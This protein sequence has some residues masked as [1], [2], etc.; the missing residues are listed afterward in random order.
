MSEDNKIVESIARIDERIKNVHDDVR[1]I[2]VDTKLIRS[3][4]QAHGT[5]IENIKK[6]C[7][8]RHTRISRDVETLRTGE[9]SGAIAITKIQQSWIVAAVIFSSGIALVTLIMNLITKTGN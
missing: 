8:E 3:Q 9:R 6:H 5:E 2:S 1:D 4:V 7:I